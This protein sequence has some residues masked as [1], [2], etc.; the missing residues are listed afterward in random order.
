ML[1]VTE[2]VQNKFKDTLI[3]AVENGCIDALSEQL[4]RLANFGN[5]DNGLPWRCTLWAGFPDTKLC[6][7]FLIE[8]PINFNSSR[9]P[10]ER[11]TWQRV[12]NG[13][14]IYHHRPDQKQPHTWGVHT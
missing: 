14:L 9:P 3:W 10:G 4:A 11:T 6:F 13:G 1:N 8:R 7:E 5:S 12:I 2:E